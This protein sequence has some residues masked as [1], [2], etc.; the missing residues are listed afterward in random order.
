M[1]ALSMGGTSWHDGRRHFAPR[2]CMKKSPSS[3]SILKIELRKGC[4]KLASL[5]CAGAGALR[6]QARP[7]RASKCASAPGPGNHN[8]HGW[9]AASGVQ[10]N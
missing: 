7:H 4:V 1:S 9:S 2:A 6:G 3:L 8:R 10:P 5:Q